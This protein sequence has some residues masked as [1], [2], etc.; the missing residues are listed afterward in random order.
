M[1]KKCAKCE[2]S[3]PTSHYLKTECKF[4]PDGFCSICTKCLGTMIDVD[5]ISSVDRLCQWLN[6][7]FDPILWAG[8]HKKSRRVVFTSYL[9]AIK[10]GQY[11]GVDW[12]TLNHQWQESIKNP[13]TA[14]GIDSV[15]TY[16]IK[17]YR[18]FW[19]DL[20]EA[21]PE[22]EILFLQNAYANIER[23]N[24]LDYKEESAKEV[25]R[26]SLSI[27]RE[28][29]KADP[30]P[31]KLAKLVAGR[32]SMLDS[33]GLSFEHD[34]QQGKIRG[35]GDVVQF[36]KQLEPPEEYV[37]NTR[38]DVTDEVLRQI[39]QGNQKVEIGEPDLAEMVERAK[40]VKN[41]ISSEEVLT[42]EEVLAFDTVD[43]SD[44]ELFLS[45]IEEELEEFDYEE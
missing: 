4:F 35:V 18:A 40:K 37:I 44:E 26:Q 6:I 8:L 20:E 12:T 11:E 41:F 32:K 13:S 28:Q 9:T 21:L 22:S 34:Q 29:A 10:E 5:D 42:N 3:I 15:R 19:N 38:R 14:L 45:A 30:D 36:L 1:N 17:R 25:A 2:K 39:G 7:V 27:M 16:E 24:K 33:A 43:Q 23:C 31:G